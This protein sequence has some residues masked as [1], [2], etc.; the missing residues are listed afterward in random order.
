MSKTPLE[1]T[2]TAVPDQQKHYDSVFPLAYVCSTEGASPTDAADW[3]REHSSELTAQS[4]RHGAVFFRGF[5]LVTPEDFDAFVTAFDLPCFAYDDSLSNAV[6]VNYTP[7]VFSA[8]EAPPEVTINLHHEMA[9][10]PFFP[11]KLFFFCNTAADVGGA[12]SICRSDVLW[13]RLVEQCAEFAHT[14]EEKGLKYTHTMPAEEDPQS[15]MGRNW[16]STFSVE[17]REAAETRMS[18]LGY[19]WEFLD[20]GSLRVTTPRLPAVRELESGRKAFFNQLITAFTSWKDERND[21]GKA[22]TFGDGSPM[23]VKGAQRAAEIAEELIFD[24]PWQPGDAALVDNYVAQH[25]R[26]IFQGTRKVLASFA[27]SPTR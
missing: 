25:G 27:A 1:V 23:D 3:A 21:P 5:P 7:R 14:C 15:G 6:R 22:V 11:S 19:T 9:Q 13:E 17:T 2:T 4:G 26:R 20:D 18:E 12:S 10:T 24:V 8:N 16:K